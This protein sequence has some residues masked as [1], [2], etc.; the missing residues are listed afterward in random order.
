MK[1][2]IEAYYE[3]EKKEVCIFKEHIEELII[4]VN[5]AENLYDE[6]VLTKEYYYSIKSRLLDK[7]LDSINRKEA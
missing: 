4:S 6:G 1:E 5:C 2:K 3:S 7:Y